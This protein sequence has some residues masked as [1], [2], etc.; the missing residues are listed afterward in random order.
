MDNI[1]INEHPHVIEY[2]KIM[3]HRYNRTLYTYSE[4]ITKS[5]EAYNK[6]ITISKK[7]MTSRYISSEK[8]I[9]FFTVILVKQWIFMLQFCLCLLS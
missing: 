1:G 9:S 6:F 4:W 5:E 2:R 3:K 8:I 7:A